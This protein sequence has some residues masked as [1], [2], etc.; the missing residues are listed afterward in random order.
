M[1]KN[2]KI[3]LFAAAGLAIFGLALSPS[4][5]QSDAPADDGT[6]PATDSEQAAARYRDLRLALNENR[7]N[8]ME[9]IMAEDGIATA[10]RSQGGG[11][12]ITDGKYT[13]SFDHEADRVTDQGTLSAVF[14]Q[15]TGNCQ[16]QINSVRNETT[17]SGR[18]VGCSGTINEE[19]GRFELDG[20]VVTDLG[21][22][23]PF[24]IMGS[25]R[26]GLLAGSIFYEGE[27]IELQP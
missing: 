13:A 11:T 24:S 15:G 4:F 12:L 23:E 25:L 8:E 10:T 18:S 14:V 7:A 16:L 27:T 19:T 26:D 5:I 21:S 22:T 9:N 2:N 6:A 20:N 3:I 1:S 17:F